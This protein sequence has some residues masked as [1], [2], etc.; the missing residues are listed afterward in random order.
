MRFFGHEFTRDVH[1]VQ[2]AQA[3]H[4][5]AL[6]FVGIYVPAFL[7]THGFSLS[8]TIVFFVVFHVVSLAF[9]LAA[10]PVLMGRF[11]LAGTL[12]LSF[13]IQILYF[14]LLNL[15]P[16][17]GIPW[18]LIAA[19]GGI[20]NITYW[21]PLN[22]L[23][24]KHA[25]KEKMGSDLGVFFALPKVFGIA[26]PIIGA[27]LVP[28]VGFWPMFLVSGLA[29]AVSFLPLI[30][31]RKEE[32]LPDFRIS[33]A[34][35]ELKK[36]RLLFFLEGLDNV[37]E[38]S[39]WFWGMFVFVLIGSL[40]VPGIVGGLESLGGAV[41][42]MLVGKH[43]DKGATRL[44]PIAS[45]ALSVAWIVRFFVHDPVSAYAVSFVSSF[46]MT[47]FLVSYFGM[48]YRKIKGDGEE[49]FMILREI[50]TTLGR[51]IVF[52]AVLVSASDPRP[53]F[54]LPIAAIAV[55]ILALFMK[56]KRFVPETIV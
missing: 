21:M 22:I 44:I 53:M 34:W 4:S 23:L 3:L 20:A 48:M 11:G 45:V 42:A 8:R 40:S 24:V 25:D 49:E 13:P 27:V 9:G 1:R 28:F 30:G 32:I 12:R 55:L 47:S 33:R 36:R 54:F 46:L 56:R 39:E 26:G 10:C 51:L 35:S 38:E 17:Y 19:V 7:L 50:P 18:A 15:F 5:V 43:A 16:I 31:I 14:V 37:I 6:S 41:F 29:L 52:G 2:V